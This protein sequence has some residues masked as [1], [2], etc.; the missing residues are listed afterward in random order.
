MEDIDARKRIKPSEAAQMKR[1][2]RVIYSPLVPVKGCMLVYECEYTVSSWLYT[3]E[4]NRDGN[5][6]I[7]KAYFRLAE[8]AGKYQC[9]MFTREKLKGLISRDPNNK[10]VADGR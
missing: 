7:E 3:L 1:G 9:G 8:A 2:D 4:Q 6:T 5:F 10:E